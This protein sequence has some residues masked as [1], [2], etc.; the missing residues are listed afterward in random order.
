MRKMGTHCSKGHVLDEAN[1]YTEPKTGWRRCLLCHRISST[2]PYHPHPRPYHE[3][4]GKTAE[5]ACWIGM[6]RR[7]YVPTDRSFDLYGGRGITVC[8][9][10]RAS[11]ANFL[12]D[13]GPRPSP[14]HSIDRINNDGNYE[15]DNC[16]WATAS[17]QVSNRR[18][19]AEMRL[20]RGGS[21]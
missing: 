3:P 13:M 12:A 9:Q 21:R 5:Y 8:D 20:L 7:C 2:R 17:Q 16:R 11:F 14:K 4:V 19:R 15:P 10:W 6:R 18:S 1:I